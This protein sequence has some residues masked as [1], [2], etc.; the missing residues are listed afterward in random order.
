[1][2]LELNSEG[3]LEWSSR[4]GLGRVSNLINFHFNLALGFGTE[5]LVHAETSHG[6]QG[7]SINSTARHLLCQTRE[8]PRYYG[9][10]QRIPNESTLYYDLHVRPE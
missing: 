3:R 7:M 9:E 6:R 5:I 8:H 2:S 1:M 10:C 4:S